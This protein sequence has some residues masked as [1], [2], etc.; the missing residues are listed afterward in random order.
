MNRH[1][2][3]PAGGPPEVDRP[4]PEIFAVMGDDG[5]R[6]MI[7]CFYGHLA[8]SD[9]Q[10]MFVGDM[11]EAADRSAD[12]FV[13]LL[14]GPPVFQQKYGPPR[15]RARHI[16]FEISENARQVW[17]GCFETTL[18]GADD[19]FGFPMQHMDGFKQFLDAFSA[20]MVNTES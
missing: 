11:N 20:W 13:Q 9:I 3:T 2:H 15:L 6:R 4:S 14:G 19:A 18:D 7:H 1:I 12:Y 17:I 8:H 16:P 5:I 10:E